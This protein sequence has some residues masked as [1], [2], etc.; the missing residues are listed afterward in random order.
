[1]PDWVSVELGQVMGVLERVIAD[2]ESS[3]GGRRLGYLRAL[4]WTVGDGPAPVT[5][6]PDQPVTAEVAEVEWWS[7]WAAVDPTTVHLAPLAEVSQGLGV[8]YRRPNEVSVA[9]ADSTWMVLSWLLGIQ[10]QNGP[11]ALAA[12]MFAGPTPSAQQLFQQAA[13]VDA[14][15]ERPPEQW[16]ALWQRMEQQAARHR[17]MA[18][19]L[20]QIE[21]RKAACD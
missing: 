3:G 1:M 12:W 6:R 18:T 5:G 16:A 11:H 4:L 19:Q 10:D 21:R 13:A 15:G 20:R 9:V 7:A 14:G 8:V 2:V 17:R